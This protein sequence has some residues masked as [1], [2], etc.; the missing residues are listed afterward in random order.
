MQVVDANDRDDE[1]SSSTTT[2]RTTCDVHDDG[3]NRGDKPDAH[4]AP[5]LQTWSVVLL[6]G[7]ATFLSAP[8]NFTASHMTVQLD[9][10]ATLLASPLPDDYPV[11]APLPS[12]GSGREIPG[13]RYAPF[14]GAFGL[15]NVTLRGG[16]LDGNGEPWWQRERNKTLL[17]TRP[18]LVEM[19]TCETVLIESVRLQNS[20]FWTLHP[21]YCR[22][23]V[24]RGVDVYAPADAPHIDGID[25][26]SCANVLITN[27]TIAAG[28]DN[29]SIKSGLDAAG[30][31]FGM[32]AENITIVGNR[33]L[34]GLGIAI[35]SEMSGDVRNVVIAN[36]SLTTTLNALRFKTGRG[37]GGVVE[38]I[39][40]SDLH[41]DGVVQ[42]VYVLMF[43][44]SKNVP[45]GN[46]TTTPIIRNIHVARWSGAALQAGE[47]DCLPESPCG[48]FT[49]DD[50]RLVTVERYKCSNAVGTSSA[51]EPTLCF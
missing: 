49:F 30:R 42:A 40:Y 1:S 3:D 25:P 14:L 37:R 39:T 10:D 15:V 48:P 32:P 35:G 38:N 2:T 5:P 16:T 26:D 11:I 47:F 24:I 31:A 4:L 46:A 29:I 12:Y 45:P 50:V 18:H 17:H 9:S 43:Y 13:P 22:D 33:F 20:A 6:P 7:P 27:C 44:D 36:N 21:V 28:D 51:S 23:V 34:H 19:H 41:V 8:L